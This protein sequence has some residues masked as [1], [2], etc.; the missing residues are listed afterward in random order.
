MKKFIL[1]TF[2]IAISLFLFAQQN[3][4]AEIELNAKE[5]IKSIRKIG[6]NGVLLKTGVSYTKQESNIKN[7]Y[8]NITC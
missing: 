1:L 6:N 5:D 2:Y 8:L 4:T 7:Y 3:K